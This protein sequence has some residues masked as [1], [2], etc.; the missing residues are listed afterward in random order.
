MMQAVASIID[1]QVERLH[2]ATKYGGRLYGPSSESSVCLNTFVS[3][4]VLPPLKY[5]ESNRTKIHSR[6]RQD[7]TAQRAFDFLRPAFHRQDI[8]ERDSPNW[9]R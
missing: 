3:V 1:G 5:L 8:K 9:G 2:I 4:S 6:K 7:K